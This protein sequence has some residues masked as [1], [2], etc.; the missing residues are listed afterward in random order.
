[1]FAAL[2]TLSALALITYFSVDWGLRRLLPW[3]PET[4]ADEGRL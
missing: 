2:A 1:M 3:Q 4:P